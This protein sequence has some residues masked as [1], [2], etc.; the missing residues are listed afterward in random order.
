MC[1]CAIAVVGTIQ[2][3]S[4]SQYAIG[5]LSKS[6]KAKKNPQLI[7]YIKRRLSRLRQPI[8]FH[9]VGGHAGIIGYASLLTRYS[10]PRL[11]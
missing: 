10:Y 2:I 11:P 7:A 3:L 1:G 8:K 9:W 4:D 5:S 6:W